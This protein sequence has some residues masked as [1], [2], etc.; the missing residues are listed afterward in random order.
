FEHALRTGD[1][2]FSVYISFG[3]VWVAAAIPIFRSARGLKNAIDRF[4]V[5]ATVV[6]VPSNVV[7]ALLFTYARETRIF[8]PP[9]IFLIPLSLLILKPTHI[10]IR[11]EISRARRVIVLVI[12]HALMFAGIYLAKIVFPYFEFRQC[13]GYCHDWAGINLG[14]IVTLLGIYVFSARLRRLC[15]AHENERSMSD[16]LSSS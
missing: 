8:F 14:M 6:T 3:F 1:T 10:F 7:L 11:K 2:L 13:A 4:L 5:L 9:F 12:F 15:A 16:S